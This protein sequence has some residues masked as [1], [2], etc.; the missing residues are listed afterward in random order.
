MR[1]YSNSK[2]FDFLNT[3]ALDQSI[4]FQNEWNS[5]RDHRQRVYMSYDS[6]NKACQ[7]GDIELAEFGH[8]KEAHGKE[9]FNY[10]MTYDSKNKEP[11]LYEAYPDTLVDVS[12]L[13]YMLEKAKGYG[14]HRTGFILDRGYFS[15]ENIRFM[16]KCGY[17]FVIMLKGMKPLVKDLILE[18]K[19]S[20]EEDRACSIRSYGV[21]GK[22]VKK[23]LYLSNK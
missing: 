14:Y 9:I 5:S 23:K 17:D 8:A 10:A 21:S 22:T 4:A 11:L 15:K 6:T 3:L 13:Q 20:F 7:A 2:V 18:N 1:P 12:Q 16:D 19:G